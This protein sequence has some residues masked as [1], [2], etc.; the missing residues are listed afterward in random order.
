MFER[1]IKN[2]NEMY[3]SPAPAPEYWHRSC[4]HSECTLHQLSPYIG[5][6]KS[7]IARDLIQKRLHTKAPA[8]Y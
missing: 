2:Y 8:L 3:C 1:D 4:A 7:S 6:L 5:K